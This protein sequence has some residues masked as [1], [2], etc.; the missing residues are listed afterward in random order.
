MRDVQTTTYID[1]MESCYIL[2][3]MQQAYMVMNKLDEFNGESAILRPNIINII[4]FFYKEEVDEI[5]KSS[6]YYSSFDN[7]IAMMHGVSNGIATYSETL[8]KND[9]ISADNYVTISAVITVFPLLAF[10]Y[11]SD[12][13][14]SSCT[15]G[16]CK[17]DIYVDP[18]NTTC[19][20]STTDQTI[21]YRSEAPVI[22]KL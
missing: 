16:T 10:Q 17:F 7:R 2:E 21:N 4:P 19:K 14:L 9:P 12:E 13:I 3:I 18:K 6:D 8:R 11:F 20:A 5:K 15:D 1:Q 22:P